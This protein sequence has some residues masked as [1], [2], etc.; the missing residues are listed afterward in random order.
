MVM[1]EIMQDKTYSKLKTGW[2]GKLTEND[3]GKRINIAGWVS[4]IRDLGGIIF[5]EIR[6]RLG[7]IQIV[8]DPGKNPEIHQI[9]SKIKDEYVITASGI[10]SQRPEDT[11]NL[12]LSTGK[13]EIYPD[14]IEILGKA[15][16]PPFIIDGD[17]EIQ[18]LPVIS[19]NLLY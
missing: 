14:K 15:E 6:D 4:T 12:N 16:T 19:E 13:I 18:R 1:L 17:N 8:A 7:V 5:V 10:V 9:L 11:H 2:C 3:I